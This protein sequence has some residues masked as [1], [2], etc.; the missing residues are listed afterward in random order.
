MRATCKPRLANS[1]VSNLKIHVSAMCIFSLLNVSTSFNVC[2][3]NLVLDQNKIT[4]WWFSVNSSPVCLIMPIVCKD[5]LQRI[6]IDHACHSTIPLSF[7]SAVTPS[8]VIS[9][10]SSLVDLR[11]SVGV[12]HCISPLSVSTVLIISRVPN[13]V[14]LNFRLL[15]A[16]EKKISS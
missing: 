13:S 8:F 3:K 5:K 12:L 11:C 6:M 16:E 4:S 10:V 9:L 2:C 15:P 7:L 14:N 1:S